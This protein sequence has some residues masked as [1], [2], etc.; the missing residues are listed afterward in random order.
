[1]SSTCGL[2]FDWIRNTYYTWT[3]KYPADARFH[4]PSSKG[5]GPIKVK[6][7]KP[8]SMAD[9]EAR[10]ESNQEGVKNKCAVHINVHGGRLGFRTF[11]KSDG[12]FCRAISKAT[13]AIVLD[14][15]YNKSPTH[16]YMDAYEDVCDIVNHVL[17]NESGRYDISRFTIGGFS[18]GGAIALVVSATM[19]P[20]TFK[21][22]IAFYPMTN[23][24][25]DPEPHSVPTFSRLHIT[26]PRLSPHN[27]PASDFPEKVL[28]VLCEHDELH[29][30]GVKFAHKLGEEG[31]H[32]E[33]M[34]IPGVGHGW[35][36]SVKTGTNEGAKRVRAYDK[37]VEVLRM[38]Y[39]Y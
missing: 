12:E 11:F 13:G 22:V 29:D 6:M 21:G 14:C 24:E 23:I 37:A 39:V 34:D 17:A 15:N 5:R 20:N 3:H 28:L 16:S 19:P 26:D 18:L 38:A 8:S 35:D 25:S 30:A 9:L 7:Y 10:K 33:I 31:K 27:H 32:V 36:K 4:I 2:N 1:M